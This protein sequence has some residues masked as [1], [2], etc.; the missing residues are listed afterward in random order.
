M[1]KKTCCTVGEAKRARDRH[2]L[3]LAH[4]CDLAFDQLRMISSKSRGASV[5]RLLS[6]VYD[7]IPLWHHYQQAQR[8]YQQTLR[9]D[10]GDRENVAAGP[11]E[12]AV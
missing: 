11:K 12:T 7:M 8:I 5:T 3:A 2:S 9:G 10:D 6:S 4:K 1:K